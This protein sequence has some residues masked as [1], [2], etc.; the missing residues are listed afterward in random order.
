MEKQNSVQVFLAQT[1]IEMEVADFEAFG[2]EAA[3]HR[4]VGALFRFR[5]SMSGQT[6]CWLSCY[7][8]FVCSNPC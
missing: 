2:V 1:R 4:E 8:N 6:N 7:W 3:E 5:C